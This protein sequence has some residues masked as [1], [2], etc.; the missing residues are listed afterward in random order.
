[1]VEQININELC[2]DEQST[3]MDINRNHKITQQTLCDEVRAFV[4]TFLS[5]REV[6][7]KSLKEWGKPVAAL[8][9]SRQLPGRN[10]T[11]DDDYW[12]S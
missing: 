11:V 8:G 7:K 1:M 10:S 9:I 5:L 12:D 3:N 2:K 4:I 6:E